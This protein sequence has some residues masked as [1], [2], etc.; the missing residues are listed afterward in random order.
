MKKILSILIAMTLVMSLM[1]GIALAGTSSS[2]SMIIYR[3]VEEPVQEPEAEEDVP[4]EATPSEAEEE[5][6]AEATPVEAEEAAEEA[7]PLE[8]EEVVEEATPVEAEEVVEETTP[9]EAEEVVE[10]ATTEEAE[11]VV[12]ETTPAEA[13]EAEAEEVIEETTPAEAEEATVE[14]AT[15]AEPEEIPSEEETVADATPAEATEEEA[16]ESVDEATAGEA[17]ES[18]EQE[19]AV[20]IVY[21]RDENGELIIDE[22]GNPIAYILDGSEAP[23]AYEKD[24]EGNLILDENGNP[25][26]IFELDGEETASVKSISVSFNLAGADMVPIGTLAVLTVNLT[27]YENTEYI[28]QWQRS[29]D[30]AGWEDIA[31]ANGTTYSFELDETTC[32]FLYR[33]SVKTVNE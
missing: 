14:E 18:A 8:A 20:S 15:E 17:E 31:G 3:K 33:V 24:E 21:Q 16:E 27:G 2:G 22:N 13:T 25:I 1:S 30:G 32:L 6:P 19:T 10:E 5:V 11:E 23:V 7:T 9:A 26:P 4:A 12:E 28:I 29:L